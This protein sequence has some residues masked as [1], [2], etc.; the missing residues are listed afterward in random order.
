MKSRHVPW[1]LHPLKQI[2]PSSSSL[3]VATS[4]SASVASVRRRAIISCGKDDVAAP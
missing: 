2:E 4:I 3:R 1:P